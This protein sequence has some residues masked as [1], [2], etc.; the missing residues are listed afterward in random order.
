MFAVLLAQAEIFIIPLIA[1]AVWV[2]QYLFR[3]PE[4]NAKPTPR[5]R[6]ANPQ[7]PA[8]NRPRRRPVT[9]LDRYLEETRKQRQEGRP[10]VL[11]EV[12]PEAAPPPRP[13]VRPQPQPQPP[14]VAPPRPSPPAPT[15]V[16]RRP[17]PQMQPGQVGPPPR[18]APPPSRQPSRPGLVEVVALDV[19]PVE[20]ARPA[21]QA[22]PQPDQQAPAVAPRPRP[23]EGSPLGEIARLLRMPEGVAAAVI[24]HEI[25]Q[26]PPSVRGRR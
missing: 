17:P 12:V 10:V 11:A 8:G 22:R 25:L 19:V 23:A 18:P 1:L 9:D 13:P 14:R 6:P 24:L 3:G 5:A 15:R 26:P 7:R 21:L 16:E 20:T 2:L 4:E